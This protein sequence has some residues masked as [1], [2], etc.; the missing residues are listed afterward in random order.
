MKNRSPKTPAD[1]RAQELQR[2][3]AGRFPDLTVSCSGRRSYV[4]GSFPI[5]Y[6][7]KTLDRYQIEIEWTDSN[8][9][10]PMLRETR[11]RIPW[12][13]E[14][15]MSIGGMACLFVPEEWLLKPKEERTLLDYLE[16]PVR[17]YFL[18]QSLFEQGKSPWKDRDHKSK[19][20]LEAYGEITGFPDEPAIRLCLEYLTRDQRIK[21]HW[22]CPCGSGKRIRDCRHSEHLRSL[23]QKVPR[24]IAKLALK[25]LQ[26]PIIR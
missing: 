5:L 2:K 20:L 24:H 12:L 15:H 4:R 8:V 17:D 26:H 1:I 3:I 22:I 6:E 10:A 13:T 18:W 25:R 23:R 14:R 9:Q 19:G 21:G 16:G 7:G 11:G